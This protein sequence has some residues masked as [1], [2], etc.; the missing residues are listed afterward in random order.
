MLS[1][2]WDRRTSSSQMFNDI[3]WY[4]MYI[5]ANPIVHPK[6]QN[7]SSLRRGVQSFPRC[8]LRYKTQQ[9]EMD[10]LHQQI[11]EGCESPTKGNYEQSNPII[12]SQHFRKHP[13]THSPHIAPIWTASQRPSKI[14]APNKL[15]SESKIIMA[16]L[17]NWRKKRKT[18][19]TRIILAVSMENPVKPMD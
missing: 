4:Q 3:R 15:F 18:R 14:S 7:S 17:A 19:K 9:Q 5:H 8:F 10:P 6:L 12:Q 13:Q 1:L 16:Q 2:L 11:A